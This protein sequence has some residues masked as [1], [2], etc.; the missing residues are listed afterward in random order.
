MKASTTRI[1]MNP[2]F[3]PDRGFAKIIGLGGIGANFSSSSLSLDKVIYPNP[4]GEG[5]CVSV[6]DSRIDGDEFLNS[7]EDNNKFNLSFRG[8]IFGF[9]WFTKKQNFWSINLGIKSMFNSTLPYGFFDF[10]KNG[11]SGESG[12][13]KTY[14][15]KKLEASQIS[16][17]DFSLGY[18]KN[19]NSKLK[20]GVKVKYLKPIADINMKFNELTFELRDDYWRAQ[21]NG[22]FHAIGMDMEADYEMRDGKETIDDLNFDGNNKSIGYGMGIDLGAEYQINRK[23]KVSFSIIDLGKLSYNKDNDISG[24]A[25]TNYS[26]SGINLNEDETFDFDDVISYEKIDSE[27]RT[28]SLPTAINCGVE[29]K[30]LGDKITTGLLYST[31]EY[32]ENIIREL[33]LSCNF[34]PFSWVYATASYSLIESETSTMGLALNF[35][36]SWINFFMGTDF[37]SFQV[38]PQYVPVKNNVANL[39]MGISLPLSKKNKKI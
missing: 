38:T 22:D 4:D 10:M 28:R 36:P 11:N 9:G 2:A 35:C 31:R 21:G 3:Q 23:F 20:L 7:L 19:I 27:K 17:A 13:G 24:T 37:I 25:N 15:L 12:N 8:D 18:S 14:N 1:D 26:F 34:H 5:G 29:Y 6:L 32:D 33:T 16:Y 39:F 30:V